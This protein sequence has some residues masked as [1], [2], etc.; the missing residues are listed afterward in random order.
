MC[1]AS[2]RRAR[3]PLNPTCHSATLLREG[4]WWGGH[5]GTL[6]GCLGSTA[7]FHLRP[8]VA[9]ASVATS[10][11]LSLCL[12]LSQVSRP[13][14]ASCSLTVSFPH[15]C[16]ASGGTECAWQ[17][18]VP[19]LSEVDRRGVFGLLPCEVESRAS[20]VLHPFCFLALSEL[21]CCLHHRSTR[22]TRPWTEAMSQGTSL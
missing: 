3:H 16:T 18:L 2:P 4:L 6:K 5:R 22:V 11:P 17:T 14:P 20:P 21:S 1:A 10:V 8:A 19:S 12:H 9:W 15:L 13:A 7:Q